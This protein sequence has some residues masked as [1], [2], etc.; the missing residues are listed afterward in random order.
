MDIVKKNKKDTVFDKKQKAALA[1]VALLVG[2]SSHNLKVTGLT[3]GQGTRPGCRLDAHLGCVQEAANW[4][5]SLTLI[6]LSLLSP[7]K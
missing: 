2:M 4:R 1:S 5:F 3:S 6:F 7:I